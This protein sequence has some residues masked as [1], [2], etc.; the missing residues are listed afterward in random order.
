MSI[1]AK[2]ILFLRPD[3]YGDLCLFEPVPRLVRHTWPQ[4]EIGVLIRK[5]YQDI[6]ALFPPVG[7]RWLTTEANPYQQGPGENLPALKALA[8]TVRAFEPDCVVAACAEQT[9]LEAAVAAFLPDVRHISLGPGLTDP[10]IRAALEAV[11]PVDWA[12]IYP[13]RIPVRA[14]QREWEKNLALADAL[15]GLEAPRWWPVAQIPADAGAQAAHIL[16]E[17]G[18]AAGKYVV[19]AAAGTANVSIKSWPAEHYGETLA[20]LEREHGIRALVVGHVAEWE[21]LEAV[22]RTARDGGAEPALWFGENGEM[23]ILGGL[24]AA[25][26]FYF[27]NDTGA[28]HL[29]AALGR[30]LVPIF[31]GGTWPRFQPVARR[32]LTVVQPLPCFG[33]AWDCY[34]VDAPCLRAISPVSVR[35]ALE[36]FLRDEADGQAVFEAQGLEA[37]ARDLIEKATP[38]LRFAREDSR[39]RLRQNKELSSRVRELDL[40]LQASDRDRDA[41]LEQIEELSGRARELDSQLQASD[42]DRDARLQ[43]IEELSERARELDLQLQASDRDRDARLQQIEELSVRVRNLDLQLQ[44]SDQDRNARLQ[45]IEELSARVRELDLQ[46]QASDQDRNARL[47]QIEELTRGIEERDRQLLA[48]EEDGNGR[49]RQIKELSARVGELDLRLRT[50]DEDGNG[51]LR[52]IEEL[53]SRLRELDLRLQTSEEDR[54]RRLRQV[55]ELS[56]RLRDLDFRL[57]TSD[58]DRD[59]RLQQIETLTRRAEERDRQLEVIDRDRNARLSQVEALTALLRTSETDRANRLTQVEELSALLRESEADRQARGKLLEE[60]SGRIVTNGAT[61]KYGK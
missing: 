3:A 47:Q 25:A 49:L 11:L 23:P 36:Q 59:A 26:R 41:R 51:R 45:Q 14:E 44:T 46:L 12:R 16:R 2:R 34:F 29:A 10:L 21:Q 15:L 40:Q 42:R 6:T 9:W 48:S 18:L 39:D 38:R 8:E 61:T 43:Q 33:C 22:C 1:P 30:P 54:N 13:E 52:Q 7:V 37:G 55:E 20:W 57:Q 53:S 4:T 31:G 50:S 56:F 35:L 58:E 24:L 5:P 28:L 32:S 19:C 17:S 60:L 27:G